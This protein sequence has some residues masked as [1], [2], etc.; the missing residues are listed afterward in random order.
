DRTI[1]HDEVL[2][3]FFVFSLAIFLCVVSVL[4]IQSFGG[5]TF[6]FRAILFEVTSA[7][8]TCGASLGITPYLGTVSKFVLIGLMFIGRIGLVLL[9]SL[10]HRDKKRPL[11]IR[12]PEESIVIG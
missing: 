4:V 9:L 10:F 3:S 2:K 1:R 12:Y 11:N 5:R 6:D 7:F 8:G